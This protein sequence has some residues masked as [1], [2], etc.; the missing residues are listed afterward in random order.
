MLL[1]QP[2]DILGMMA[3][4][5]GGAKLPSVFLAKFSGKTEQSIRTDNSENRQEQWFEITKIG[6]HIGCQQQIDRFVQRIYGVNHI[7]DDELVVTPFF[8]RL[9]NHVCRQVNTTQMAG[10]REDSL[11]GKTGAA[12]QIHHP[13]FLFSQSYMIL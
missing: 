13:H 6:Q 10:I 5:A 11:A 7:T 2:A 1:G 12:P 8:L 4:T 9:N 3:I